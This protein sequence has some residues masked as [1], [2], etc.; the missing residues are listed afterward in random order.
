MEFGAII[1]TPQNPQCSICPL[2]SICKSKRI[3][4][5]TKTLNCESIECEICVKVYL[6][7]IYN[8]IER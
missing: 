8:E 5:M 6:Y 7:E 3:S 1:C 4:T 2:N